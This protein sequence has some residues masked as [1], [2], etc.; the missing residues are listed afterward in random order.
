MNY[1]SILALIAISFTQIYGKTCYDF[2][3]KNNFLGKHEVKYWCKA[4]DENANKGT[5]NSCDC[6]S[7][8]DTFKS[9]ECKKA[10][11]TYRSAKKFEEASENIKE[12]KRR[13][14]E[15]TGAKK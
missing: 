1:K 5:K 11:T 12:A 9:A 10:C 6:D 15:V 8:S 7:K 13:Y 4:K 14:E 2:D 3:E